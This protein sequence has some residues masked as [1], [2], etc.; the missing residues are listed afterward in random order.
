MVLS[1][2][3]DAVSVWDV[4]QE[5]ELVNELRSPKDI[6]TKIVDIDWAASDRAVLATAGKEAVIWLG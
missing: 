6:N 5:F 4:K 2:S 1:A 3:G